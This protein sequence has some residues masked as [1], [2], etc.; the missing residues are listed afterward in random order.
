MN[1]P[2][3]WIHYCQ[4]P[5]NKDTGEPTTEC[6]L[7][8]TPMFDRLKGACVVSVLNEALLTDQEHRAIEKLGE[9][10]GLMNGGLAADVN[11]WVDKIHQLQH[12]I[13]SQAAARAYPKRYR[14]FGKR[15][16]EERVLVPTTI[17]GSRCAAHGIVGCCQTIGH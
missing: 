15:A 14:L 10:A 12:T 5:V 8:K 11:E 3:C 17:A 6:W 16:E 9:V 7:M 2:F 1:V 4:V 13:M